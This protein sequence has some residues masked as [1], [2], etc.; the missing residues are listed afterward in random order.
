M[1]LQLPA[2]GDVAHE[3]EAVFLPIEFQVVRRNLDRENAALLGLVLGFKSL[4]S[5]LFDALP[6]CRP[7]IFREKRIDVRERT[8]QEALRGNILKSGRP[9]R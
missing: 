7:S 8:V 5:L 6:E 9:L 4:R 3:G 2:L 1:A